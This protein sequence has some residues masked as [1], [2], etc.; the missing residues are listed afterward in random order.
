MN[1]GYRNIPGEMQLDSFRDYD[2][3]PSKVAEHRGLCAC[4]VE[5]TRSMQGIGWQCQD[6]GEAYLRAQY[7]QRARTA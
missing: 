5:T 4:G 6:C 3:Q 1:R 7:E 2:R